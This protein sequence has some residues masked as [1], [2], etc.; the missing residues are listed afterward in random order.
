[1]T[2]TFI[3]KSSN[4]DQVVYDEASKLLTINF[5]NGGAWQYKGVPKEVYLGLQHAP[6]PGSYFYRHIRGHY[7]EQEV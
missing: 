2:E 6:S 5:K 1:M 7:V 3:P 4:L